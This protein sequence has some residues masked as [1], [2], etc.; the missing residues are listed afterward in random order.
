MPGHESSTELRRLLDRQHGLATRRQLLDAGLTRSAVSWRLGR[1][2]QSVL[3]GVIATDRGEVT[4]PRRLVASLLY[5]GPEAALSGSTAARWYGVTRVPERGPVHVVVPGS[6]RTRTVGF[7]AI[8]RSAVIDAGGRTAGGIR[9]VSP[10]RAVVE[11]A[12]AAPW[13]DHGRAIVIEAVQRRICSAAAVMTWNDLLGRRGS[14]VVRAALED[15]QRGAWSLPEADLAR[16]VAGSTR[17]PRPLANPGLTTLDELRLTSPDLYFDDVGL[18]V[19]VHSRAYHA[20]GELWET[21]VAS[22]SDLVE[23]GV[24][25]LGVTPTQIA[26][27]PHRVLE[28]VERA[29]AAAKA[30]GRRPDVVVTPRDPLGPAGSPA[31]KSSRG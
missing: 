18:A 3:P 23:H 12:R 5:A 11:A 7:A 4:G 26:R 29:Y 28:R 19:M 24:S 20:V 16:V 8:H 25:V 17:L 9:L 30:A 6:H 1:S 21:T 31:G 10:G 15:V 27:E 14:A 2:W 13:D 22:D